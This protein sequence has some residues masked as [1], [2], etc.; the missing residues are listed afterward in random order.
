MPPPPP[1]HTLPSFPYI[2]TAVYVPL[3]EHLNKDISHTLL[4]VLTPKNRSY[5]IKINS[6]YCSILTT[7]TFTCSKSIYIIIYSSVDIL[8]SSVRVS[9]TKRLYSTIISMWTTIGI[10]GLVPG[11]TSCSSSTGNSFHS[12]TP[13]PSDVTLPTRGY[14]HYCVLWWVY[15]YREMSFTETFIIVIQ[16]A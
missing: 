3:I 11:V 5:V 8:Y 6:L 12:R 4:V 7:H 13:S 16:M 14:A 15:N 1:T 9:A 2:Y 10:A